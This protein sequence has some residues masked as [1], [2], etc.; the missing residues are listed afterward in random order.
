MLGITGFETSANFVEEQKPG[1]F[2]KTL[3]NMWWITAFINPTLNVL[4]QACLPLSTVMGLVPNTTN[5]VPNNQALLMEMLHDKGPAYNW[6]FTLVGVDAFVVLS[7]AVL[8][9]YVGVLGLM[10]RMAL[11]RC[12][13]AVLLK[14]NSLFGTNH[15]I[16]ISFCAVCCSLY[17]IVKCNVLV[18]A[19]TYTIRRAGSERVDCACR[20]A[21]VDALMAPL[22]AGRSFLSVMSV[23]DRELALKYSAPAFAGRIARASPR[24]WSRC[25]PCSSRW[26]ATSWSTLTASSGSCSTSRCVNCS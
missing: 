19:S 17:F 26:W 13:P 22:P 4:A 24:S 25:W 14:K 5:I 9:A 2:P 12:L 10:R 23:C 21:G 1:V 18:L 15:V 11:D 16:I 3:R 20:A 7:G 6:I 8:T